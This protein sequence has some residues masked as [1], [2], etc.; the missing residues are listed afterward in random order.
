VTFAGTARLVRF[1]ARM[2][3][4]RLAVWIFGIVGLVWFTAVSV[5]G[6]YPTQADLDAAAKPL[7]DNAAIIA[8]NGPT[9]AIDTLGG[10]IVFQLGSFGYAVIGLM[11][12]FLVGRHTRADEETGRIEL[13]RAAAVGR[14]A[15]PTAALISATGGLAVTG[16][17]I[18]LVMLSLGLPVAGSIAYGLAMF[19]FGLFFACFTA[20][21]A[22]VT[23]HTRLAYA[24]SGVGIGVAY[25]LRV[26]G[27]IGNGKASWLSPM[28]W[29]MQMR[30]YADER[31]WPILLLL[32]GSALL[33]AGA[34]ALASRRD[35]G[36]G[37]VPPKPGP[38]R[39]APWVTRPA[40]LALRL[41]GVALIGWAVGMAFFAIAYGSLAKDVA[42]LIGDTN[43]DAMTE[44][45]AQ[46][47]GN[48]TDS[49]FATSFLTLA[50]IAGGFTIAAV[51][52]L[53]SEETS[54]RA[55]PLL[56]TALSRPGWAGSHLAVAVLG[57]V[58]VMGAIGLGMSVTYGISI[59]DL[60]DVPYLTAA[61]LA[62][63][64]ALWVLAGLALAL[65]GLA[66]RAAPAMW[67]VL[68]LCLFI[69]IFG[70]LANLP[71][72]IIDLSPFQHVPAMP[73]AGFALAPLLILTAVAAA[74]TAAGM[75]GFR[76]RD[77]GY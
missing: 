25:G 55:E 15:P 68:A 70:Q 54:G 37:L 46:A 45:I 12:M 19:G 75:A 35:L 71:G 27:D 39:A 48:L 29:S 4:V 18:T 77:A 62:F 53:R 56:A 34:F 42:D 41:Q 59:G 67:G 69:G 51:L 72:W 9:Y 43:S 57:S 11:G 74:L 1:V 26:I 60:S 40:G 7:Y 2:D 33:V 61:A 5:K 32:G 76:A 65:F 17:L 10:Q 38:A 20:V 31:W 44:I 6:L 47:R 22:Q 52:R 8:F 30:A 23:E 50:L 28:G 16:V 63:A 21:T 24:L 64:P 13:V 14:N 66:P 49:Y 58:A 3:R 73:A 36:G